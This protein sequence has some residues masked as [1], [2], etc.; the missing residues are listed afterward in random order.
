MNL[1]RRRL[2]ATL[3]VV[4]LLIPTFCAFP[5]LAAIAPSPIRWA[6]L[7]LWAGIAVALGCLILRIRRL[8]GQ[9]LEEQ[10]D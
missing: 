7:V 1:H 6:I 4:A 2:R 3:L 8:I 9:T 5:L 10:D